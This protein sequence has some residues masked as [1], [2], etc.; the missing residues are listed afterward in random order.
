MRRFERPSIVKASLDVSGKRLWAHVAAPTMTQAADQVEARLR[1]GLE[2]LAARRAARYHDTGL[3]E[4]GR[5]RH[6]YLPTE[7]PSFFPRPPEDRRTMR[8]STFGIG[9]MTPEE[10]VVEMK[11]LHHDFLLFT[12]AATGAES[13]VYRRPDNTHGLITAGDRAERSK[14]S[15]DWIT[16]DP[17]P[18]PSLTTAEAIERLDLSED[19]F[20]FF[21]DVERGRGSIVHR[22]Y[23]G[24]YGLIE[25]HDESHTLTAGVRGAASA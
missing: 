3:A 7:R 16:V 21:L 8:R 22:C 1:R 6:G 5:W 17:A 18:A 10:A 14:P 24:H 2:I 13:V 20:V 11:L 23:D 19:P 4:P 25:P 9:P 12:D 15:V